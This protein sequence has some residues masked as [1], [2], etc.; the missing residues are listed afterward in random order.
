M[1]LSLTE[2]AALA[3][4]VAAET[5]LAAANEEIDRLRAEV[6]SLESRLKGGPQKAE[7]ARINR[8]P[9]FE[10]A[11]DRELQRMMH[12]AEQ[13]YYDK[14]KFHQYDVRHDRAPE[15]PRY[16]KGLIQ[17]EYAKY[18][19]VSASH[20][21]IFDTVEVRVRRYDRHVAFRMPDNPLRA[22]ALVDFVKSI[23][24]QLRR[25]LGLSSG[26]ADYVFAAMAKE[27]KNVLKL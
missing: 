5:M 16:P 12:E 18:L 13:R 17:P 21:A 9:E 11:D 27:L 8:L 15:Y 3:R 6:A 2:S 1:A 14:Y 22:D 24:G 10:R 7:P 19:R 20:D 23:D 26:E 4:A 25:E